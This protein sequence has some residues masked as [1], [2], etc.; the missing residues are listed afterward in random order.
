M[1]ERKPLVKAV[2]ALEFTIAIVILARVTLT[3][4]LV[5]RRATMMS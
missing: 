4:R 1:Q 3:S 5:L 2:T